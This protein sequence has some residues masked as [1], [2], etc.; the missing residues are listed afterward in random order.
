MAPTV[1]VVGLGA[2]GLVTLK[3]LLEE[4]FEAVGF[5]RNDYLGGLWHFDDGNKISVME[6]T[7][8]NGSKQR[9]CFT[10]FPFPEE[11]PDFAPAADVEKYLLAYAKHFELEKHARLS[12]S[13]QAARYDN[14]K[15]Q[16]RLKIAPVSD[17]NNAEWQAFDKVVFAMGTD[18]VP[19]RPKIPGIEKFEGFMEHSVN[20]KKPEILAGKRVMVLGFGNTA[21]DMSTELAKVTSQ[22]YLAHRHGAIILPRWVN[23]KPV[24]HVRTYRKYGILQLMSKYTPSLWEKTMNSVIGKLQG[25]VFDLKPEWRFSPAPSIANQRPLVSD[26]LV[27]GLAAGS[28]I[29]THGLERVIDGKTVETSDG[30]RYE[31]DA[32]VFCTGFSVDF[33]IVGPDA[34]PTRETTKDWEMTAGANGRSLP[35][36]YQNLFSLDHPDSLAFMGNLS[37]M[38]PAFFILPPAEEMARQVDA[39]HAWVVQLAKTGSVMPAVVKASSWMDWVNEVTGTNLATYLGYGIEGWKFW[40]SDRE[41]CGML[42]DGLLS[43]HA[44]RVFPGKRKAWDGAKDAIIKMN[45][46]REARFGPME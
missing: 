13:I 32:I 7:R 42:M 30:Q 41:F 9:G 23:D 27:A 24:D 26:D 14:E 8:S 31:I 16:W 37:F 5:E 36:L 11:T 21:A 34:D 22:V 1:A 33:S 35:R 19:M 4:G 18:Q 15:K 45:K 39:H 44:Y 3:N 10:D 25:Q 40:A 46:D 12:T 38:N 17:A 20:F 29:S 2:L 6:T 28:I 43:P